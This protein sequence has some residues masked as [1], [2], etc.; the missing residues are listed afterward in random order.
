MLDRGDS[1]HRKYG[2]RGG[3]RDVTVVVEGSRTVVVKV[4]GKDKQELLRGMIVMS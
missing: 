4:P 3:S 1:G 2:G